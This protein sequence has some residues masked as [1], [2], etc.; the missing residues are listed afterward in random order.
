MRIF[1]AF[2]VSVLAWPISAAVPTVEAFR[3][4]NE[5]LVSSNVA[6]NR[7]IIGPATRISVTASNA[8]H[9]TYQQ[10]CL[11]IKWLM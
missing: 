8:A 2:A 6:A 9:Y 5:V 1:L 7:I 4:T 10:H 3:G 11:A